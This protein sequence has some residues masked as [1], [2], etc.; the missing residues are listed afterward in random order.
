MAQNPCPQP[1]E[2]RIVCLFISWKTRKYLLIPEKTEPIFNLRPENGV[3]LP[4]LRTDATETEGINVQNLTVINII[5]MAA[6]AGAIT[7][8][9]TTIAF[10]A[11]GFRAGIL[12]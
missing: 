1:I 6:L 7:A 10:F 12:L 3:G 2:G 9:L 4:S 5:K 11:L 8:A